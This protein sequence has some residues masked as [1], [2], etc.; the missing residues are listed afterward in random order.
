M[1]LKQSPGQQFY[2][3][4]SKPFTSL[5]PM[6]F[7]AN[8]PQILQ[9]TEIETVEKIGSYRSKLPLSSKHQLLCYL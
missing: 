2:H 4:E 6:S 1:F 3:T 7:F 8:N 5:H 9:L